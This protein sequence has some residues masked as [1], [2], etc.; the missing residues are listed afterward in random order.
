MKKVKIII[1]FSKSTQKRR[2][3]EGS[4]YHITRGN[5]EMGKS[6]SESDAPLMSLLPGVL[7][8]TI[9]NRDSVSVNNR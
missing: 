5:P 3:R 7:N 1:T 4:S 6:R 2:G 8:I 9:D